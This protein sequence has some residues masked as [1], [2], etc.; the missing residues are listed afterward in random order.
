MSIARYKITPASALNSARPRNQMSPR[1]LKEKNSILIVKA[2]TK[3][4]F[5]TQS[6]LQLTLF[7]QS[8]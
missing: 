8:I 5:K 4:T 3:P 2:G 1:H 7:P 6:S